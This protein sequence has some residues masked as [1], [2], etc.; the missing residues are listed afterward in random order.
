MPSITRISSIPH[1]V[2]RILCVLPEVYRIAY[3]ALSAED[4]RNL[5]EIRLRANLP[6]SFTVSGLNIPIRASCGAVI[7]NI[8]EIQEIIGRACDGS[9]YSHSAEM[10]RG[11]ISALGTR[12]GIS[13]IACNAVDGTADFSSVTSLCIRI[14]RL[15]H[16]AA[17]EVV[18]YL[19]KNGIDNT[20]GILAVSPPNCGKTTFLRALARKLSLADGRFGL[21][22]CVSDERGEL[23]LDNAFDNCFCDC[24]SCV[25]KKLSA[26]I[27]VRSLSAQVL[28]L[29]EIG[30]DIEADGIMAACGS[31]VYVAASIHGRT[32][33]E[34]C[35][36]KYVARLVSSGIFK[37][38]YT[39]NRVNDKIEGRISDIRNEVKIC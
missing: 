7:S 19:L 13:G 17:D 4:K 22:V 3:L 5:S 39:L 28:V 30:N 8:F 25:P 12:I 2:E 23:A 9:L 32:L 14:P 6:S 36:R 34:A 18:E 31:G 1:S 29:D 20:M 26:E 24:I 15:I 16:S 35:E 11:Y 37:T 38:V 33:C 10:S 21:R 27:A